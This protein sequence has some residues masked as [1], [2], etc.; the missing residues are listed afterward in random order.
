VLFVRFGKLS[1]A[2]QRVLLDF[3]QFNCSRLDSAYFAG[4][5]WAY[6]WAHSGPTDG[7][8]TNFDRDMWT[9]LTT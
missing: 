5:F 8:V 9:L 6:A 4:D 3:G 1:N 7:G 2:Q